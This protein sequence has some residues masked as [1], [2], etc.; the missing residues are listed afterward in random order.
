M[1]LHMY[2][3]DYFAHP[4]TCC[5][6][7]CTSYSILKCI[8]WLNTYCTFCK[9]LRAY[10]C[11]CITCIRNNI[12]WVCYLTC[13]SNILQF[14]SPILRLKNLTRPFVTYGGG[15]IW[16]QWDKA[17][18]NHSE[19]N[20]FQSKSWNDRAKVSTYVNTESTLLFWPSIEL[21]NR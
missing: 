4:S 6:I 3:K 9:H 1:S 11:K 7:F 20:Y 18:E 12:G 21:E 13:T 16:W 17:S 14:S 2:I 19:K 8:L 15:A 10:K 5:V